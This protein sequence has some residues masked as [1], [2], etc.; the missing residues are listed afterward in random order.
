MMGRM[1][2]EERRDCTKLLDLILDPVFII[3]QAISV[4]LHGR[5]CSC[6]DL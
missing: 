6:Q 5:A 3:M 2:R 1:T 4:D